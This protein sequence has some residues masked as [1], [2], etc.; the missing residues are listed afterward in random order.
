VPRITAALVFGLWISACTTLTGAAPGEH[1][2][3]PLALHAQIDT[4]LERAAIGPL[5]PPCADAEFLRRIHL[6]LTG[7]VPSAGEVTAFLE[8]PALDKRGKLIDRL[9]E[10]N[11]FIRHMAIELDVVLL[12]RRTDTLVAVGDWERYLIDF[13]AADRPLD[14]LYQELL[15]YESDPT[16]VAPPAKFLLSRSAEPNAVTRDVGRLAFGKDLQCAQCHNHPLIADYLQDDY[17]G[18]YAFWHRT[19]LVTDPKSK[20]SWITEQAEGET[21]FESVFTGDGREAALPRPPLGQVLV[22]EPALLK[23]EAYLVEPSANQAGRP[24]YSRR[25]S[26][27]QQ[28]PD[29]AQFRRNVANRLWQKMFGRGLVHPLDL[30]HTDN[31]PVNPQ[32]LNLLADALAAHSFQLRPMLRQLALTRAYQRSSS[33]PDPACLNFQDIAARKVLLQAEQTRVSQALAAAKERVQAPQ[34]TYTRLLRQQ[35]QVAAELPKLLKA[36]NEAQDKLIKS[37]S[38]RDQH[39]STRDQI[40][41][42]FDAVR[43]AANACGRAARVAT[44]D[45]SLLKISRELEAKANQLAM[46]LTAAE[47]ALKTALDSF[48]TVSA[49]FVGAQAAL[50]EADARQLQPEDITLAERDYLAARTELEQANY[51]QRGL[52]NSIELCELVAQFEAVREHD[53]AQADSLWRSLLEQWTQ[54]QQI[55]AVRPLS[56]EQL[57]VAMLQA[58]GN[59]SP[60][61]Q[62]ALSKLQSAP[63]QQLTQASA[64][65]RRQVEQ[66]LLQSALLDQ[67]RG[68]LKQFVGLFAGT[69]GEDFQAT[70]NQ[71]LFVS[72]STVI[73]ELL[74]PREDNLSQQLLQV[75]D[76]EQWIDHLY[77]AILSRPAT[78]QERHEIV[79]LRGDGGEP[80]EAFVREVQWALLSSAEF[81]F[82]H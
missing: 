65:Q 42:E 41:A 77:L 37:Q 68:S 14:Q 45:T 5:A 28:L 35:E 82:N 63:P 78:E 3:A 57:W 7:G 1:A 79:G 46:R 81:R 66:L 40:A 71:A 67:I 36:A 20:A 39:Q 27:A 29:N 23:T 47:S 44:E 19:S 17:Y 53:V 59:W 69:P 10:S 33:E 12:E 6:D 73:D 4:L 43:A 9:M 75:T 48:A 76:A 72:N 62:A 61:V 16:A 24:H 11:D 25:Q 15:F 60:Q 49:D 32:V 34:E 26:L 21:S 31:P 8:D 54:R 2:P 58:T 50:T 51:E 52:A 74:K 38:V 64:D 30:H 55:A 22:D 70:V 56:A 80:A 13:L 18:L